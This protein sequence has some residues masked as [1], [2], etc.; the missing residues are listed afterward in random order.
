MPQDANRNRLK[1][2]TDRRCQ[3]A[4][5]AKGPKGASHKRILT[6]SPVRNRCATVREQCVGWHGQ[7]EGAAMFC[8][9]EKDMPPPACHFATGS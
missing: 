9:V 6:P 3:D 7:A 8:R 1:M 2:G 4:F 5:A